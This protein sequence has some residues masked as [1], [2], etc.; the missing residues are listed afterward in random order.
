MTTESAGMGQVAG[1]SEGAGDDVVG[2]EDSA[3]AHHQ[4][5]GEDD[6]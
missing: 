6:E 1:V 5:N 2:H 4:T 3:E